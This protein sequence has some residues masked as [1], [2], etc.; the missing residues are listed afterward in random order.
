LKFWKTETEKYM[1]YK[2]GREAKAGD[3]VVHPVNGFSGIL[4]SVQAQS[5]SCNGRIAQVTS[6]DPFVTIGECL[7]IDDIAKATVPDSTKATS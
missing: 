5:T 1:H 6:N 3:R 7:H 4:H 2:N